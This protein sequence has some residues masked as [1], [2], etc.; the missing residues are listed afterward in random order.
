MNNHT[1][2][3]PG[4]DDITRVQLSNGVIVLS[5]PN[6]N[7]PSVVVDGYLPVGGIFDP[8]P[9]LGLADFTA[10]ALMRGTTQRSFQEIY[11]AL[12]SCGASLGVSGGTLTT[13]FNG[14]ALAEDLNL[15]LSM[16]GE[17]L[18]QP[19][20]PAEHVE[21]LRAQLLT[22]LAIRAQD[23]GEMASL[24]FDQMVYKN[25]PFSRPEDGYPETIQEIT[26]DNLATF[27]CQHYGSRG[28]I[29]AIVG[30]IEPTHA[31]DVASR[32]FGDWQN[33]KQ[34]VTPPLPPLEQLEQ[35]TTQR[36]TIPGKFQADIVIGAAGPPR[37][38][39][40]YMAASLGNSVL[41]QFG[42]MGRMGEILR[43]K[44]GLAYYAASS[45]GGGVGPGPWDVSI[46]VDP[47]NVEKAIDLALQEIRKFT[48]QAI[49]LEE[50]ADS[51]ANYVGRLPLSLESNS[52]VAGALV[53]LERHQLGLDY[54]RRYAD[55]VRI[56]TT[57]QV[58]EVA[59]RYLDPEKLAIAVAG[60]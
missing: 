34:A 50:L 9:Q 47:A 56:V 57:D 45:L 58:L 30:A 46:G 48:S 12:E 11:D 51:Q 15:L 3:L 60:P 6:F 20:F 1:H 59:R 36:V 41:G 37:A 52:G 24:A 44:A 39:P 14:R 23:T 42:M 18:R 4:A 19:I 40:D 53:N 55:L 22:A 49:H 43:E 27:H 5:R 8:D 28:M 29:I 26:R 25:H 32:M 2:S 10:A 33:P 16:L 7:S 35:A 38:S 31:V 21:R 13:G 54:Y 17:V